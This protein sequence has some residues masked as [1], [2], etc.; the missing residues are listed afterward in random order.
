MA[1]DTPR[2]PPLSPIHAPDFEAKLAATPDAPP[3]PGAKKPPVMVPNHV[4]TA[5]KP[6]LSEFDRIAATLPDA[7]KN[8]RRDKPAFF[9]PLGLPLKR[10]KTKINTA[11][12]KKLGAASLRVIETAA[13]IMTPGEDF[14]IAYQHTV[15]CQTCLPYRDPGREVLNWERDNG[16]V[17]MNEA[18]AALLQK[19]VKSALL[20]F[21]KLANSRGEPIPLHAEK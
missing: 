19:D 9:E 18:R 15:L 10:L 4:D 21:A 8:W 13:V 12:P 14:P 11:Q 1:D 3:R 7:P 6:K 17:S 2:K 20:A 16:F 5:A